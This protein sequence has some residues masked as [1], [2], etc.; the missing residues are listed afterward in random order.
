MF[1]FSSL[2]LVSDGNQ[3]LIDD[4]DNG[5]SPLLEQSFKGV[6]P[7][8][9]HDDDSTEKRI[10]KDGQIVANKIH[11][12]RTNKLFND[13]SGLLYFYVVYL[14]CSKNRSLA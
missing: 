1:Y 10:V 3:I 4:V 5:K 12:T 9:V 13:Y 11:E 14:G 6:F 7:K 2:S 8:L